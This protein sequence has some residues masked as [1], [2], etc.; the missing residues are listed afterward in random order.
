M[1][2]S[3]H[4]QLPFNHTSAL[5]PDGPP[6]T[7]SQGSTGHFAAS[8]PES[9]NENREVLETELG[10]REKISDLVLSHYFR[11]GPLSAAD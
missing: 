2:V 4:P 10:D 5:S 8:S 7:K 9:T 6:T 3:Q 1:S 11:I